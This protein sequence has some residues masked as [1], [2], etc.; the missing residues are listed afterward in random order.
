MKEVDKGR[1]NVRT[2]VRP[3]GGKNAP[4]DEGN[5]SQRHFVARE[6][7]RAAAVERQFED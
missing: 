4:G 1:R 7:F 5:V 3:K 2:E 6:E